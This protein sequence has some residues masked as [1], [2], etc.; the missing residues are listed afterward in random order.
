M[1]FNH[2]CFTCW[3]RGRFA[4]VVICKDSDRD[5]GRCRFGF[6]IH[7]GRILDELVKAKENIKP[8]VQQL[9]S[10]T[11]K[12]IIDPLTK[13]SDTTQSTSNEKNN[14]ESNFNENYQQEIENWFH[15][16]DFDKTYGSKKLSLLFL[17]KSL[18]YS[19]NELET[20]AHLTLKS[21]KIKTG[22]SKYK[23]VILY[24]DDPNE[25]STGYDYF[26]L[27]KLLVI[28]VSPMK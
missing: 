17:K 6:D 26:R 10:L 3:S 13:L 5:N 2:F 12:F 27:R 22:G 1:Q 24:W 8:N 7:E 23:D 15:C 19:D 28:Q 4:F 11:F 18:N 21:K 14:K 9:F 20:S 25:L 16:A